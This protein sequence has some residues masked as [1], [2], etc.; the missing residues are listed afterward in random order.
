MTQK[1][2]INTDQLGEISENQRY[3]RS[4]I[5]KLFLV[6]GAIGP[7]LFVLIFLIEGRARMDYDPILYPVSSL[8][9][10]ESGW[11]Q[12]T[13]F[14]V[15]GIL[16]LMFSIGLRQIF[17][18][19]E[20]KFK[21]S[22]LIM[23]VGI[24]LIG[25]GI[26]YTDPVYGYPTDKPL[27]L[28]QFTIRGHLHDVF[29]L[30]VYICLPAACFVF[31]RQFIKTGKNGWADYSAISGIIVILT[32]VLAAIGFK[33]IPGLVDYAGLFQRLCIGTGCAWMALLSLYLL[34]RF[35]HYSY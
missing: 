29:S 33:Q 30:L 12:T 26:C 7:V 23:L 25:A 1:K 17:N 6:C 34:D 28:T 5:T 2:W 15:A 22:L 13:N 19:P 18:F 14:I 4:I 35:N 27:I 9:I 11:I 20:K 24:G 32:F 16:L 10:G 8:S 21:G 3:Q 31:R